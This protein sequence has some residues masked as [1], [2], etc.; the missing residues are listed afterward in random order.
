MKLTSRIPFPS[1]DISS[2]VDTSPSS[3]ALTRGRDATKPLIP[4][5]GLGAV[6]TG[7]STFEAPP[8]FPCFIG[9]CDTAPPRVRRSP[10]SCFDKRRTIK[11]RPLN[12][13]RHQFTWADITA[14]MISFEEGILPHQ[15]CHHAR[16]LLFI[17]SLL[18]QTAST[19]SKRTY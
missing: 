10:V 13:E 18:Y 9:F 17:T 15:P 4:F 6:K 1:K 7:Q 3:L 2:T 14:T 11:L 12:I 8:N 19:S 16:A 5:L